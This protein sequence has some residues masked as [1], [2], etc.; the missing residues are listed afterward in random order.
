MQTCENNILSY[1]YIRC[2]CCIENTLARQQKSSLQWRTHNNKFHLVP[3]PSPGIFICLGG[4]RGIRMPAAEMT[5]RFSIPQWRTPTIGSVGGPAVWAD[6]HALFMPLR[7]ATE[8]T[9]PEG[10]ILTWRSPCFS[11]K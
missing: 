3:G 7:Y 8:K 1:T 10:K 5:H 11:G 4:W 9:R 6:L 2:S